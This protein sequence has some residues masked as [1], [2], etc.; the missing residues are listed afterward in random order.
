MTSINS[1]VSTDRGQPSATPA[2][3]RC[4]WLATAVVALALAGC[5][6]GG[7]SSEPTALGVVQLTVTDH[8]GTGVAGAQ[9]VGPF[10]TT[11]T[12]ALGV[13]LVLTEVSGAPAQ[14]V[15][16]R[17]SFLDQPLTV[18]S[19]P[20][21]INDVEVSL[22]R[23]TSAAG[24]S[25]SSRSG[26]PPTLDA[27]G[28]WLSFEVELVVVGGDSQ[29]IGGLSRSDFQLHPCTPD[30]ASGR[31]DCVR[32]AV[33]GDDLAYTPE[34]AVPETA[35]LVR[36]GTPAPYAA[37][38]LLDQSGSI[39]QSDPTAA[40]LYASKV[41]LDALG[42]QDQAL[43]AAFASGPAALIPSQPLSVY[44]PARGA[45]Q[46]RSYFDTLEA[47]GTQI[48]GSTP[49]YDAVDAL[50]QQGLG[51]DARPVGL[52]LGQAMVVFTD[53]ADTLCGSQ[54]ACGAR[55]AQTIQGAVQAGV[56]IFTVGLSSD[57][58]VAALGEL[59]HRTGGALLYADHVTQLLPLYG[60]VGR[61]MSLSLDTYR[62]RWTVRAAAPGVFRPGQTML[63]RVQVTA[64]GSVFDVPFVV[65]VP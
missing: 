42:A 39:A 41:F 25:L 20:G 45:T 48:G 56:R 58:D 40:R 60:S 19:T 29:T 13:T 15:V 24:G 10:G 52:G 37:A 46:A 53:G 63:G 47:L 32:G 43:L 11:A 2:R 65:G 59:A 33:A 18:A 9:V 16:S 31:F 54:E 64:A 28:Q 22:T 3:A 17:D 34:S 21:Q 26:R 51:S 4:G 1:R 57:V 14:V 50:R 38:L 7:G 44:G 8:Y 5:G 55:R 30:P 61:L 12:D 49:L 62:L 23:A 36:G 27:S 35:T 6:G